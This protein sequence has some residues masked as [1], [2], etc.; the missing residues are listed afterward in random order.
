MRIGL[1]GYG[2]GGRYFH[3][4]FI[5]AA[6]G[7]ELV[8][9]VAR[10]AQRVAEV[11][12]DLPGVPVF[13][14]LSDLLDSGVDAVTIST[15]PQT[16]RELVLEAM[17]RGVNVVA[18]KPFA[19]TAAAGRD[20]VEAAKAAGVLL[21][22]FHNRRWDTDITTLR[23]VLDGGLLGDIWR[24]DSRFDLDQPQTLEAGPEGGLLRDL[25]SHL[26]D[27]ALWL[28]GPACAVSANL[29]WLELPEGRTDAG[30]V[31]TITHA[32]GAHS[33]VSASKVNRTESRELRVF[34]SLGSY[35]SS[36]TDVQAQAIFAGVRPV[37]DLGSWGY[38]VPE[39]WGTLS[40]ADGTR[41]V[42]SAQGR[43]AD[44]YTSFAA[45]VAGVGPQPVPAA[46]AV[47]TL[48]VLDAARLSAAGG[49]TVTL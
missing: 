28:L 9:V 5:V 38:E 12:Q 40:T 6:N 3:A 45:A 30:F 32:S 25:G 1:V 31:I 33:H 14:S 16:R 49:A 23:A 47:A 22:V 10:A 18:D 8:G 13:E 2:V 27:Q 29:D 11:K 20:L 26:V 21:S 48:A 24:F 44:Y 46:E 19:P 39:R 34:G 15:P 41:V 43:Y 35:V 37:D 36:Q 17:G 7:C 4:P 42:P